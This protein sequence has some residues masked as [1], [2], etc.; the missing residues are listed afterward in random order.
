[1]AAHP[2]EKV[3][4]SLSRHVDIYYLSVLM[5]ISSKA[6]SA[7]AWPENHCSW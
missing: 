4:E 1:M 7:C 5:T 2:L 3:L 6:K